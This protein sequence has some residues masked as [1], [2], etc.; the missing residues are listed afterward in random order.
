MS[1]NLSQRNLRLAG[2]LLLMFVGIFVASMAL[3]YISTHPA[4]P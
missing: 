2:V 4:V 1:N 3:T